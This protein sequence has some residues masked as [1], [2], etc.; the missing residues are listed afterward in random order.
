V[1]LGVQ[2]SRCG[3]ALG[4]RIGAAV[5]FPILSTGEASMRR[6]WILLTLLVV[7]SFACGGE[8]RLPTQTLPVPATHLLAA[9]DFSHTTLLVRPAEGSGSTMFGVLHL[10]IG[11]PPSPIL[12]SGVS[13]ALPAVQSPDQLVLCGHLRNPGGEA[14][15]SVELTLTQGGVTEVVRIELPP[16]PVAPCGTF[17]LV[18]AAPIAS[19]N[20]GPSDVVAV[21]STDAG[22]LIGQSPGPDAT[23]ELGLISTAP[24]P[25]DPSCTVSR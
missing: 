10:W 7:F 18:A 3:A 8:T 6:S 1:I 23:T 12:P 25:Q 11:L 5:T 21:L 13:C 15:Q 16:S 17:L 14:L 24:P 4:I 22:L 19:V 9:S 2:R 20:P